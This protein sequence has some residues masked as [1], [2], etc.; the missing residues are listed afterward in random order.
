MPVVEGMTAAQSAL[1]GTPA[2]PAPPVPL[3]LVFDACVA[4]FAASPD[5][6]SPP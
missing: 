1:E 3:F 6:C 5:N 2:T 4:V